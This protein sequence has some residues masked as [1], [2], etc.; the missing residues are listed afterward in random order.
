MIIKLDNREKDLIEIIQK[1][2]DTIEMFKDIQ[3]IVEVLPLGDIILNDGEKDIIIFERKTIKDLASSIRDGRYTEQSYRLNGSNIHNHNV[4]YLIE[5]DMT[6]FQS[7]NRSVTKS[8]IYSSIISMLLFKGFSVYRSQYLEESAYIICN[9]AYKIKKSLNENKKL[10]YNNLLDTETEQTDENQSQQIENIDV[11]PE[12]TE[13]N[14][15]NVI[16]KTKKDNITPENI[17]EIMLCQIPSVSSTTALAVMKK[18]NNI[19]NLIKHIN[20]DENCLDNITYL[21]TKNKS[22]KINKNSIK[23]IF[24]FLKNN[25]IN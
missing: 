24:L 22:R 6:K 8:A 10:Y 5:G 17:G 9:F 11:E 13:K 2:I 16:K 21:D 23:N 25:N 15:V 1:N 4:I 20:E 19:N 14:Y 18:F 12:I 7:F 3:V